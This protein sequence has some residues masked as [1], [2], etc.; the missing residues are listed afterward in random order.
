MTP[1][2]PRPPLRRLPWIAVLLATAVATL[3]RARLLAVGPDVDSDAYAHAVIARRLLLE[4]RDITIHW[5]WLPL[6]HLVGAPGAATG[7]DLTLQRLLSVAASA[8][9]PLVLTALLRERDRETY[10]PF[11]AGVLCALWPLHV[12]MGATAQ[13]ESTFEL[14][15]LL[16]CFTWQ[17]KQPVATGALLGLAALLRYEAWVL[18]GVFFVLWC[19][20]GRPRRGA[21]AWIIPGLA[22]SA[23]VLLHRAST[24]EW[25]WFLR[26]NRRYLARAWAELRLAER[27]PPSLRYAPVWY[28]AAIPWLSAGPPLLFALAGLPWAL[29]RAP[30]AFVAVGAAL[31]AF[32]TAVWVARTNLGLTRHFT[33]LVPLYAALMAAGMTAAARALAARL[34]RPHLARAIAV[35][36]LVAAVQSIVRK[37]LER[38]LRWAER[39]SR[40]LYGQ[41]RAV[42]AVVRAN[43]GDRARVFS[44]V[45]SLEVFLALPPWRFVRW[46]VSDV[47]DFTLLVEA[48]QRGRVLVVT[49][50]ARAAQ[51]RDG[52]TVLYRDAT[53]VVLRRDA[54]AVVEPWI[55]RMPPAR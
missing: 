25:F 17:R 21:W 32:V 28:L 7:H 11:L 30:R 13:P 39:D 20:E 1:A 29:R 2:T 38:Q 24:G 36:L 23:W 14:I 45:K 31:L 42:A 10:A 55:V 51:L 5:V 49:A 9:A 35:G 46:R 19:C 48:S 50:P 52:V 6:W 27:R 18:P 4:W 33:V 43:L 54:P 8:A 40:R 37:P 44:D 16:A 41:E 12:V 22:I 3:L 34:G 53:L 26:E 47:S 15:A